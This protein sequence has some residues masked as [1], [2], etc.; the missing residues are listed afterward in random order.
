MQVENL[1]CE[2]IN[3]IAYYFLIK[4]NIWMECLNEC[5]M[6][7]LI[8]SIPVYTS[9]VALPC[10]E[11]YVCVCGCGVVLH[12]TL[13]CELSCCRFES[14]PPCVET[15]LLLSA[16]LFQ[17]DLSLST[18]VFFL[19]APKLGS[20]ISPCVHICLWWIRACVCVYVRHVLPALWCPPSCARCCFLFNSTFLSSLLSSSLSPPPP[21]VC[22]RSS[23]AAALLCWILCRVD[24]FF[25]HWPPLTPGASLVVFVFVL[26]VAGPPHVWSGL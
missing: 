1:F 14:S 23:C 17:W 12:V 22:P 24:F 8:F 18:S 4:E 5:L 26:V 15:H 6:P 10:V 11:L 21:P 25:F 20:V 3:R 7:P 19:F 2:F 9:H 16:W 13:W